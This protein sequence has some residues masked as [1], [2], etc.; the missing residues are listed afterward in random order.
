MSLTLHMQLA[1]SF[2]EQSKKGGMVVCYFE[3]VA[4]IFL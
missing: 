4:M 2:H 1:T 3:P